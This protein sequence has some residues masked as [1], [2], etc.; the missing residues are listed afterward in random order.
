MTV[1]NQKLKKSKPTPE[2]ILKMIFAV[3][4]ILIISDWENFKRGLF[5]W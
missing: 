2:L 5:G 4:F 1:K 3:I